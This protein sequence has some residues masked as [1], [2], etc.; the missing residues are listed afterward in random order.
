MHII[1]LQLRKRL[2]RADWRSAEQIPAELCHGVSDNNLQ[3][4]RWPKMPRLVNSLLHLSQA[5]LIMAHT[6]A[7]KRPAAQNKWM[8]VSCEL[9]LFLD[10]GVMDGVR[11]PTT[12]HRGALKLAQ[13][14]NNEATTNK[15]IEHGSKSGHR[16]PAHGVHTHTHKVI[17][18]ATGNTFAHKELCF[19]P[20]SSL[21]AWVLQ[22]KWLHSAIPNW[23]TL[24]WL[25]QCCEEES[26]KAG[27]AAEEAG[28]TVFP[29]SAHKLKLQN[30]DLLLYLKKASS[31]IKGGWAVSF[32]VIK[33]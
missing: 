24:F 28:V 33:L 7:Q 11:P 21:Y 12:W 32:V 22:T 1:L 19:Q 27:C 13:K 18:L 17:H 14:P 26:E 15:N 8:H 31:E 3:R 25:P 16:L 20:D 30:P 5:S 23:E 9:C 29:N 6:W 4:T 10:R 2:W